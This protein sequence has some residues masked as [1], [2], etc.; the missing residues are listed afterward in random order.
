MKKL[1]FILFGSIF[2]LT[3]CNES[4]TGILEAP[5]HPAYGHWVI[6]FAGD[7]VGAATT[8]VL[9]NGVFENG[10]KLTSTRLNLEL[11][12]DLM[13]DVSKGGNLQAR[14]DFPFFN[15]DIFDDPSIVITEANVGSMQGSF[16]ETNATGTYKITLDP[17]NS[18]LIWEGEWAG[19]LVE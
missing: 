17:S 18:N 9:N 13:G 19:R 1:L 16:Y 15:S 7:V 4:S 11:R 3:S 12:F 8:T 2:L 5:D 6:E 14:I 10:I